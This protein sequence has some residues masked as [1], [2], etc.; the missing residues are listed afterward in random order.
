MSIFDSRSAHRQVVEVKWADR[1][2]VHHRLQEL[3]IPC[4]CKSDFPLQVDIRNPTAAIQLWSVVKQ[5]TTPRHE[6]IS[7]LNECWHRESNF[8]D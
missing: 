6:L 8:K 4:Y 7:W 3:Q 1:W 2:A 5:I